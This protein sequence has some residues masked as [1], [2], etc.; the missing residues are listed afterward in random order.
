MCAAATANG[1]GPDLHRMADAG[2]RGAAGGG[3]HH[4]GRR[5]AA[6]RHRGSGAGECGL[7]ASTRRRTPRH[8]A[9]PPTT[10]AMH[11][12]PRD[13][14]PLARS[15][16]PLPAA[17]GGGAGGRLH[18]RRGAGVLVGERHAGRTAGHRG[19]PRHR[20]L[21]DPLSADI[22]RDHPGGAGA[23]LASAAAGAP[24]RRTDRAG[25]C[26]WRISRCSWWTRTFTWLWPP[27]RYC[28]GST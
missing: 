17:E 27:R 1:G 24:D 3:L 6:R 5:A 11:R 13:D 9:S 23:E 2:S 21:G 18:P 14:R 7:R 4:R 12:A 10:P 26:G 19:D 16:R 22:A 8:S 28:G 25:L 15:A 20:R